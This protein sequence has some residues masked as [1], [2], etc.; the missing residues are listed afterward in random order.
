MPIFN[1]M[2]R[3]AGVPAPDAQLLHLSMDGTL[4]AGTLARSTN[5]WSPESGYP[6]PNNLFIYSDAINNATGWGLARVTTPNTNTLVESTDNGTHQLIQGTGT[7]LKIGSLYRIRFEAKAL[8]RSAINI[9]CAG[10]AQ[11]INITNDYVEYVSNTFTAGA[12]SDVFYFGLWN[13]GLSYVG[14]GVSGASIQKLQLEMVASGQPVGMYVPTTTQAV[15]KERYLAGKSGQ[16]VLVE[17]GTVNL[18]QSSVGTQSIAVTTANAGKWTCSVVGNGT[19]TSSVGTATAT[20]YGAA[21]NGVANT[22]TVTVNGTVTYTVSG[23]DANSRIQV[24]NKDYAS[25]W[26]R[27]DATL[28][29]VTRGPETFTHP[30]AGY[31]TAAQGTVALWVK[32]DALIAASTK[33]CGFFDHWDGANNR[34]YLYK[35]AAA[36]QWGVYTSNN[37]GTPTAGP[38]KVLA[39][40][41]GWHLFAVAWSTASSELWIDGVLQQSA[42]TP[43]IP[44][45]LGTTFRVGNNVVGAEQADQPLDALRTFSRPLTAPEMLQL[46]RAGR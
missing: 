21:S 7:T 30:A 9:T 24:E 11:T 2:L 4:G 3:R 35:V 5:A 46:Y 32:V 10:L 28:A 18:F 36:N 45:A 42:V 16:S 20:G 40:S 41:S 31:L 6:A 43:N 12:T 14:D 38:S 25:S 37:V 17:S 15:Y 33:A 22:I 27:N 23:T 39:L 8:G 19:V 34:L 13:G 44:S 29:G 26:V 1:N